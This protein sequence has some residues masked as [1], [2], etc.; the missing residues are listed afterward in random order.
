MKFRQGF[1]TNSSSTSFI[2]A[3][4]G[5]LDNIDNFIEVDNKVWKN[6][7]INSIKHVFESS[8]DCD[9]NT[10]EEIFSSEDG[11]KSYLGDESYGSRTSEE[12]K[13]YKKLIKGGYVFYR[14]EIS[15]HNSLLNEQ[16]KGMCD[17]ENIILVESDC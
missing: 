6:F 3:V 13:R 14:K 5:G 17:G 11:L 12:L 16:L 10:A 7:I 15:H 8:D 9:T 2:I 4:K 1:V